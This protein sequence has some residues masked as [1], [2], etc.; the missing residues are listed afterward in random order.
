MTDGAGAAER[1]MVL[2]DLGRA[3]EA[4][5]HFR[6]ALATDPSNPQLLVCL[7]QA[8]NDQERYAEARDAARKALTAAPDHLGGLLILAAA[9]AG[10]RDFEPAL[11]AN[12]RGLQIAPELPQLHRQQGAILIAQERSSEALVPL[13]RAQAL[14]PEN[15][16][17]AALIGAALLN[18][19]RFPEAEKAVADALRLDPDNPEAHRVRGLLTLRQGGGKRAVDAHRTALRLDPTDPGFREDLAVAMKSRNPLYGLL[20]RFS[21]WQAGLPSGARWAILLAP[22]LASRILRPFDDQLWARVVLVVIVAVVVLTWALEPVMNTVLL[23]S[24]YARNLLP[25][26]TKL[27]TYAFLAYAAAAVTVATA[28]LTRPSD[29][30]LFLAFGLGI[31]AMSVGQA[32]LVSGQ[33]K[34][35]VLGLHGAGA[36]LAVAATATLVLGASAAGPLSVVLLLSGIAMVWV[37]ALA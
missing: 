20:L 16:L 28:G 17:T 8:L 6:E 24:S 36:L 5:R 1:G 29:G 2:L 7:A 3:A 27:A 34:K 23:C 33:R 35:L 14:D 31:W 37:T 10:L 21:D 32:H 25:R 13:E 26:A 22:F 4:E 12:Q 15:S 9:L 11:E 30:A 19:R 18:E